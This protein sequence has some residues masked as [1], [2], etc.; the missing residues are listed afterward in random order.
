MSELTTQNLS[1]FQL[2]SE[3]RELMDFRDSEELTAEE[4][5][6]VD[7]QIRVYVAKEIT[8]ID[9]LRA[10]M[11]HCQIMSQAAKEEAELQAKR[12]NSW[13]NRL[14]Y[15]K[16]CCLDAMNLMGKKKLEGRTGYLLAKANG[17]KQAL[18]IYAPS[19]IPENLVIY[20]GYMRPEAM[21]AIPEQV[22]GRQDFIFEREPLNEALRAELEKPCMTCIG[23]GQIQ[24]GQTAFSPLG[25]THQCPKCN[26]DGKQTVPGARLE[27]RGSHVEVK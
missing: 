14:D 23:V 12:A 20:R 5:E 11:R 18:T 16:G 24:A 2:E 6:A 10:Y 19:L 17:G 25:A 9:N 13:K 7:N 21:A 26:G 3:L 1:L 27:P 15:L 22:R 4:R 8:K